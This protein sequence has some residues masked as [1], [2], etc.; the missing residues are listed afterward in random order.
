MLR[1]FLALNLLFINLLACKGGYN[2]C[3]SKVQDT[4]A[5]QNQ[6]IQIPISNNQKLIYS[7]IRPNAKIIKHDPFLNLYIIQSKQSFKY[8]FRAN[9]KLS[10]GQAS[11]NN[12]VAIEG[13]IKKEQVGLN[14]L[15][16]FSEVVYAPSLLLNSCCALEGIVTPK[17]IIQIEYIDNFIKNKNL[18]Y[19]DI[20]IRVSDIKNKVLIKRVDPFDKTLKFKKGDEILKVDSKKVKNSAHLMREILFG[21]PFV[22]HELKVKRAGKTLNIKVLSKKRYGG[23]EVGDT[24]LESKGLYFSYDLRVIKVSNFFKAYGLK[25]DD[26]LM[27]VNYKK[28]KTTSDVRKHIDDF[29]SSASLLFSRDDFQFFVNVK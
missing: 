29:T 13:R 14:S 22:K 4:N 6:T 2:T 21:G 5:I 27:Q 24:F 18:N 8:P 9:Y 15:A 3:V 12:K 25:V 1:V 16:T 19:G 23:A 11:V 17:G 7:T 28:V 26:K 20:G 10:L